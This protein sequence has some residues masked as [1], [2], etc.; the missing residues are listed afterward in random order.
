MTDP[1]IPALVQE[2]IAAEPLG[3]TIRVAPSPEG[4]DLI[5]SFEPVA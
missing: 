1:A 4:R 3:A 5:Q 2:M